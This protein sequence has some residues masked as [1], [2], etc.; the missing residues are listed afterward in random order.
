ML[1][2]FWLKWSRYEY[3]P[4]WAFYGPLTPFY[5]YFV[6]KT[7]APAYFCTANPGFLYGGFINYPKYDFLKNIPTAYLPKTLYLSE[8]RSSTLP[9]KTPFVA[10]PNLG[11]RGTGVE[12]IKNTTDWQVYTQT[13]STDLI[14]QDYCAHPKEFGIFYVRMPM[15]EH[16]KII[17]VTEK[18][19]LTIAGDGQSTIQ[20]LILNNYR[21]FRN[22]TYLLNKYAVRLKEILPQNT[23]LLLEPI[24][25]HSRGTTFLDAS[26]LKTNAL[27]KAIDA[28]SKNIDGFYYGRFDV[29]SP[30]AEALKNGN[31]VILEV[32]GTNSEATH[33]YDPSYSLIKAYGEVL[34]H[35]NY[36]HKI[37]V[38]NK[39]LGN[40]Y[41]KWTKLAQEL[42][43]YFKT[44]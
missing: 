44:K 27:E 1:K 9:L 43:I 14:I 22:K 26:H 29:K 11:E 24:G 8:V 33:I 41:I 42:L 16:G 19:F 35:L 10:K 12:I 2:N 21:A 34:R 40:S 32:N 37:A 36:Q 7:K 13:Y 30:S 31:F 15:E 17:S 28:V 25:N 39:Q 20:E 3:W 23:T 6:L 5:I 18:D 38:Q 4:F